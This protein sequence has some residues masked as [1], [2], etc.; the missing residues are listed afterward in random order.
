M[1]RIALLSLLC[2]I[3]GA[4]TTPITADTPADKEEVITVSSAS[5]PPETPQPDSA[6]PKTVPTSDSALAVPNLDQPF[7]DSDAT[8]PL[9]TLAADPELQRSFI[10]HW[11]RHTF[12]DTYPTML[13]IADCESTDWQHWQANGQLVPNR[14]RKSSAAGT[15]QVLLGLH[16]PD[17]EARNLH[18]EIISDYMAFV[19]YLHDRHPGPFHD[20]LPSKDGCWGAKVASP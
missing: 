4:C 7:P 8:L 13:A 14:A 18:M 19:K 10:R 15:Y 1:R 17:I 9:A 2:L 11:I 16:Q 12:P 6:T 3:L 5:T 20:W